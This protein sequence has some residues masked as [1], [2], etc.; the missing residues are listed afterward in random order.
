[1]AALDKDIER[2]YFSKE[3]IQ[4]RVK[5]LGK[6]ITEDY[7]GKELVVI[8]ILRGSFVFAADLIREID[9]PCELEF[10]RL[11]SYGNGTESSGSVRIVSDLDGDIKDKHV[12]IVEDILD[13]GVT[14]SYLRDHVLLGRQPASFKI[15]AMF[16]KTER[17]IRDIYA[18]Y[19][20]FE[21]PNEFIVGYGL[22]Y[23]EKYRNLPYVGVLKPEIYQK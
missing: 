1:M 22:D 19:A 17:R 21:T 11:S 16:D 18:D 5:E 9:L 23:A 14:L 7:A 15:C 20:G 3:E 13:T 12:L 6:K 4:K 10:M 8:S 2:V